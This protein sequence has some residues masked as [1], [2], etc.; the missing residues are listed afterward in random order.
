MSLSAQWKYK[1]SHGNFLGRGY[2]IEHKRN[3]LYQIQETLLKND[4]REDL[5]QKKLKKKLKP[6]GFETDLNYT[7]NSEVQHATEL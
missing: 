4:P 1:L 2:K 6:L 5:N 7:S 3:F